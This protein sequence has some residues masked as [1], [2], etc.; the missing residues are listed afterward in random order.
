M[1]KLTLAMMI[2]FLIILTFFTVMIVV[3]VIWILSELLG[4][5]KDNAKNFI[6]DMRGR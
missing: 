6:D 4:N 5:I 1:E 2:M 3:M